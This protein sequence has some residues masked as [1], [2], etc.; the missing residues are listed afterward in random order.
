LNTNHHYNHAG[1]PN[2]P[3]HNTLPNTPIASPPQS[4][5]ITTATNSPN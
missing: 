1:Y 4:H 3:A 5:P 2:P